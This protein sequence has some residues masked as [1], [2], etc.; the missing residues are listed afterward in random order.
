[1][2]FGVQTVQQNVAWCREAF[3][4]LDPTVIRAFDEGRGT[5]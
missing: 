4:Y 3:C 2:R 1:M 5:S